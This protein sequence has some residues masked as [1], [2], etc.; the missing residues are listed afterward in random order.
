M[1]SHL[2]T[3]ILNPSSDMVNLIKSVPSPDVCI[4]NSPV[5]QIA[6]EKI[7]SISNQKWESDQENAFFVGDLGEVFR[8]HLRWKALLPRIEP[9][10]AVKCNP[11]PMVIK[12]LAS[13]GLGFDCASK[14]EIQQVLN[15]GVEPNRIIY[16]NPCKQASFIRYAAQQNVSRM[17]FDN[18]E[19]LHKIKKLYPDAELVLRI[20]TDD[21]N[22]LCQLGLKFGAPLENVENLLKTA[23]EL[24]LN[25]IGVS[26]HVG[27]G[28]LD[29]SAFGDAVM[30]ARKVFDQAEQ[31]GFH[32]TLLDVGG[33][34]PGN[35]VKDGITFE[36][37][38]A[39]LGPMVDSLF[40]PEIRVI[41]EP[42]RYYVASAFTICANII[43]RRTI[44]PKAEGEKQQFMYY[45]N[46]G[47][48][49][50]FNCILFDHQIVHPKVLVKDENFVYGQ[51]L[52]EEHFECSVWGPTCDSIDCLNK[53]TQLPI[54]EAGDWLYY[55]NMG[56]YTI[57]AA[58]Q[59][60]GFRKSQ[61]YYTNTFN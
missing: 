19:E 33:G 58:S 54:L 27:S 41:A 7:Q 55:E 56:A 50:S 31:I 2:E 46:D 37:V 38:A 22:S 61:V 53:S 6:R 40:S 21:S 34:F 30:R 13:L 59:F 10:F 47:M 4:N 32:F 9:F 15:S 3:I 11:D 18:S 45:I 35:D 14:A 16:A 29:E 60:N 52:Q 43:G 48:Y 24:E 51:Q 36:K 17:T 28:C 42:G 5:E 1:P 49:G 39:I 26:F 8:Q 57:C 25:V 44:A 20:L 23:K 12:L